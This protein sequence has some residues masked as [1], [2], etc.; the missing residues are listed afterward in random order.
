MR[1]PQCQSTG[2]TEDEL[3]AHEAKTG[4]SR[5]SDRKQWDTSAEY[6]HAERKVSKEEILQALKEL[7][8]DDATLAAIA[9]AKTAT[10]PAAHPES[11]VAAAKAVGGVPSKGGA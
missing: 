4:H 6:P 3:A 2:F 11:P 9:A 10:S 7:G 1:C 5:G 8:F